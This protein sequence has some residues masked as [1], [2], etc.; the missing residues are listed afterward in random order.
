MQESDF[1]I[2]LAPVTDLHRSEVEGLGEGA[3][4]QWLGGSAIDRSDLDPIKN[5]PL[6]IPIHILHGENDLRVPI[7]H[8]RDYLH[9]AEARGGNVELKE[10]AGLG[11]FELMDPTGPIMKEILALMSR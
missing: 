7:S 11:H 9:A 8:S 5:P 1:I 2:A 10:L 3:V 6:N 4:R